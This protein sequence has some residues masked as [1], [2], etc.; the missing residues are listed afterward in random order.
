MRFNMKACP[1]KM[2]T[3]GKIFIGPMVTSPQE[4]AHRGIDHMECLFS[5][6]GVP[7]KLRDVVPDPASLEPICKMAVNDACM[8]TNPRDAGSEDLL[9]ICE[10]AW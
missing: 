9:A 7:T 5:K 8:L 2:A 3:V 4:I 10:E 1:E 6:L